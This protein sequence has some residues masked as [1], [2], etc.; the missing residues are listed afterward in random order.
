MV[1]LLPLAAVAVF[2]EAEIRRLTTFLQ[3]VSSFN[4]RHPE[5]LCHREPGA[6]PAADIEQRALTAEAGHQDFGV[7][8]GRRRRQDF[9][10]HGERSLRPQRPP[11]R[12]S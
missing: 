7:E 12:A 6:E 5:L 9:S 11:V 1:G 8:R 10:G 2:E 4:L 3:R